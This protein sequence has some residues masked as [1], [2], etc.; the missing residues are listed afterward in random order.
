MTEDS[1]DWAAEQIMDS[2][3][4]PAPLGNYEA[5]LDP[6]NNAVVYFFAFLGCIFLVFAL[7]AIG[8][9]T[10]R[11]RRRRPHAM[12]GLVVAGISLIVGT[13]VATAIAT[14]V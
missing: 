2:A 4:I 1:G 13:A 7:V 6:Y 11:V 9:A 8:V 14:A 12:R 5:G 10:Y 3:L